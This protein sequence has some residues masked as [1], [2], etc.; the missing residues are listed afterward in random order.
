MFSRYKNF[1]INLI[2][3][4]V[5]FGSLTGV[6]TSVVIT[7]YKWCAAH[8]IAFSEAGYHYMRE[9]LWVVL[10]VLLALA[11]VAFLFSWIYRRIPNLQGGG[12]PTSI[13]ILRGSL[14]CRW[15][16]NLV[17]LFFLSLTSFLI[18][19]PLGN[20]GPSVQ[21]GTAIGK[22]SVSPMAKKHRAWKRY[23][24]TGGACAGFSIATGALISGILFAIE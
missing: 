4:A 17:G 23:S 3:P 6:L 14:P 16:S 19:V 24:M 22:G 2:F 12:I 10:P 15:L 9:H 7:L 11:G 8:V 5:I 1:F 13:G 21:M 18:G 20:E